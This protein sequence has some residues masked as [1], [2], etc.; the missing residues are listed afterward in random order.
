MT[1]KISDMSELAVPVGGHID[2]D[3]RFAVSN[4]VIADRHNNGK[5]FSYDLITIHKQDY[6]DSKEYILP[7]NNSNK[8]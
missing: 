7:N 6:S 2:I 4:S 3:S 5:G 1:T 8:E